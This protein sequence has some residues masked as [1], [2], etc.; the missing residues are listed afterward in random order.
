MDPEN[1]RTI[2]WSFLTNDELSELFDALYER[3]ALVV[4][5]R[6]SVHIRLNLPTVSQ[7]AFYAENS[8]LARVSKTLID[9]LWVEIKKRIPEKAPE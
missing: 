2:D 7:K 6:E 5:A 8:D 9:T 4:K 3:N 1:K